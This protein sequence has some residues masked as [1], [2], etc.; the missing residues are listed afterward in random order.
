MHTGTATVRY[1]QHGP[2]VKEARLEATHHLSGSMKTSPLV[3]RNR[4]YLRGVGG[5]FFR[6]T[7]NVRAGKKDV[8]RRRSS[9]RILRGRGYSRP[10]CHQSAKWRK[11]SA[12]QRSRE[13][14]RLMRRLS[15][16]T[17]Q[18]MVDTCKA[19]GRVQWRRRLDS[20]TTTASPVGVRISV[21]MGM[22]AC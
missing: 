10:L 13:A 4:V 11:Q 12:C 22:T 7:A 1:S 16:S 14:C 8:R 19:L 2:T 6:T 15:R 9:C 3:S 17:R 20:G 18:C 5:N 21:R